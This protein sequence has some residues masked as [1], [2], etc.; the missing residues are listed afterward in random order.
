QAY[1]P[2]RDRIV[3]KRPPHRGAILER[4]RLERERPRRSKAA[5]QRH[6]LAAPALEG[7]SQRRK[8]RHR[9]ILSVNPPRVRSGS[10]TAGAAGG[11]GVPVPPTTPT[12]TPLRHAPGGA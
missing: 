2:L 8:Q 7:G 12:A 9:K 10:G 5:R 11:G 3:E 4:R 1:R 6:A